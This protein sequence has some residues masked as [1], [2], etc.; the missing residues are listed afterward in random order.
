METRIDKKGSPAKGFTLVEVLMALAISSVVLTIAFQVLVNMTGS[1]RALEQGALASD[2]VGLL[3]EYM[4]EKLMCVGGDTIRPWAAVWVEDDF[5][6][7]GTDRFTIVEL[8]DHSLQCTFSEF[9]GTTLSTGDTKD[10]CLTE[11]FVK[12]QVIVVS[13]SGDE[14]GH[15]ASKTV[16]AVDTKRCTA[17]MEEGQARVLD[18][19]PPD[20]AVWGGGSVA[21]VRVRSVWLDA[22]TDELKFTEDGDGDGTLETTVVADHIIDLQG[23]LGF[24][25]SPWDWRV[26]DTGGRDDEW[27]YNV[28][29]EVLGKSET[30]GLEAARRDDLRLIRVGLVVGAPAKG[31]ANRSTAQVLNGPVRV[32]K[33]WVLRPFVATTSLRNFD[34]MR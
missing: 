15:W 17:T 29:G 24:D 10:C 23:A 4:L 2:E 27:L 26:T 20:D 5:C 6:G 32:R 13:G 7:D 16:T 9:D 25:V 8:E 33:G 14:N 3:S 11:V 31:L 30:P 19:L 34:V 1:I 28:E 21:V 18:N 22:T 12:Q